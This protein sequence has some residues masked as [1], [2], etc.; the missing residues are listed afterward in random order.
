MAGWRVV[1]TDPLHAVG[2]P[3]LAAANCTL[4]VP[5]RGALKAHLAE[6]DALIVRTAVTADVIA[7]APKLRGIVRH[8]VGLDFIPMEAACA[9]GIPVANTPGANAQA[10]AE[11]AFAAIFDLARHLRQADQTLRTSGWH[12]ARTARPDAF[13]LRGKVLGIVGLGNV[14]QRIAAIGAHGFGMSVLGTQRNRLNLPSFV[15]HAD[16]EALFSASDFVVLSCAL[17]AETRGMINSDLIARMKSD[18]LLVNVA[19]GQLIDDE[20]L[21]AALA[22]RRIRGAALDVF[23]Q[24]PIAADNAFHT[25]DNVLLTP[26]LAS[27]TADSTERMTRI[28]CEEAVRL[29]RGERPLSLA[30]PQIWPAAQARFRRLDAAG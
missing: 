20:A 17:T 4:I 25:L 8:G 22:A 29:L 5:D 30:N 24:Q 7:H 6:A 1:A 13:E 3:I 2:E 26:H 23:A 14:G 28:A 15:Q 10:V 12:A 21:V 16:L 9:L 18:A 27:L 11:H 19:R